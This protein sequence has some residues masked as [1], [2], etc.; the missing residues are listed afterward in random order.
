MSDLHELTYPNT[1]SEEYKNAR[2]HYL[3]QVVF[4][5]VS[6]IDYCKTIAEFAPTQEAKEFLLQQQKEEEK[7]LDMLTS[8][9]VERKG[10]DTSL[11][12]LVKRLDDIIREHITN[13]DYVQSIFLQHF[14]V[15][16]LNVS[17]L[18]ELEHH[19]DGELSELVREIL[20][21]EVRHV[22]FGVRE[23]RRILEEDTSNIIRK[24]LAKSQR[25]IT[26]TAILLFFKT[27]L[28]LKRMSLPLPEALAKTI[29]EYKM[30]LSRIGLPLPLLDRLVLKSLVILF[31]FS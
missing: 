31:S 28:D 12:Y 10:A 23:L 8:Y 14:F 11:V 19:A 25:K 16:G 27:A 18:K 5:E 2:Y 6:A 3:L 1:Q 22:E 30:N 29:R 13:K 17:L 4:G 20:N 26:Y 21:D 9:L 24:E 15:E 7:H